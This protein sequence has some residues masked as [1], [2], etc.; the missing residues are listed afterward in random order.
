MRFISNI[1]YKGKVKGSDGLLHELTNV[2]TKQDGVLIPYVKPYTRVG[3]VLEPLWFVEEEESPIKPSVFRYYYSPL[4]VKRDLET[5]LNVWAVP[6][7]AGGTFMEMLISPDGSTIYRLTRNTNLYTVESYRTADGMKIDSY[8]HQGGNVHIYGGGVVNGMATLLSDG[9]IVVRSEELLERVDASGV[10]WSRPTQSSILAQTVGTLIVDHERSSN[11]YLV[12]PKWAIAF[13]KE[14]EQLWEDPDRNFAAPDTNPWVIFDPRGRLCVHW[15]HNSGSFVIIDNETGSIVSSASG[16]V[17]ASF[18]TQEPDVFYNGKHKYNTLTGQQLWEV[19]NPNN[20]LWRIANL[21]GNYYCTR[22]GHYLGVHDKTSGYLIGECRMPSDA[23]PS[24]T[25][26]PIFWHDGFIITVDK[27]GYNAMNVRKFNP[28][29]PTTILGEIT[30]PDA[31]ENKPV[32]ALDSEGNL[33]VSGS[34]APR[35]STYKIDL[36]TFEEVWSS[37]DNTKRLTS[38]GLFSYF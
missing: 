22:G 19:G 27:E 16:G 11:I 17:G 14:G 8:E 3:G 24:Y 28:T 35:H 10:I 38:D 33:Y 9:S 26:N 12:T 32:V 20:R 6:S 2:W 4:L 34:K 1:R 21:V 18:D 5:N 7:L 36:N 31:Q 29:D 37:T 25:Y 13:T 30:I 15:T 23:S